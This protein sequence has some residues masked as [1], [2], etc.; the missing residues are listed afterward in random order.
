MITPGERV[1]I[2][3]PAGDLDADV[4]L[5]GFEQAVGVGHS[6]G[7]RVLRAGGVGQL[8][9]QLVAD[10]ERQLARFGGLLVRLRVGD[11]GLE[12]ED[13]G[14]RRAEAAVAAPLFADPLHGRADRGGEIAGAVRLEPA[15]YGQGGRLDL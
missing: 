7:E 9:D 1:R 12:R 2:V 4:V 5:A 13:G 11:Q 10:E 3:V 14:L 8:V 15:E 6:Q